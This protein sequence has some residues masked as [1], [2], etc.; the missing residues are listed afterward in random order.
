MI[1]VRHYDC[2][3]NTPAFRL[4]IAAQE[5]MVAEGFASETIVIRGDSPVLVAFF[6]NPENEPRIKVP[7]GFI[8]YTHNRGNRSIALNVGWVKPDYR[9]RGVYRTL[10]ERLVEKAQELGAVKI[11][12]GTHVANARMRAVGRALGR[13]EVF[14]E[15]AFDVPE[16]RE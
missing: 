8:T 10:W 1:T 3:N 9:R 7:A 14:V 16:R 5:D 15:M 4:A 13:Y 11:L 6:D 2:V 12:G